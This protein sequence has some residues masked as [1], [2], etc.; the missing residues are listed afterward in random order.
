MGL[1]S[2]A[3]EMYEE[4]I[5]NLPP[6]GTSRGGHEDLRL[7]SVYNLSLIYKGAGLNTGAV[8]Q[9]GQP[10]DRLKTHPAWKA[11]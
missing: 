11:H 6:K 10:V 7:R 4:V 1:T 9:E 3:Q 2:M 8:M 5:K